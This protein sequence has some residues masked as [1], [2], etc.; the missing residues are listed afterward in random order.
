MTETPP[1]IHSFLIQNCFLGF[2]AICSRSSLVRNPFHAR[3]SLSLL[4]EPRVLLREGPLA[5]Q[6]TFAEP[7]V[8]QRVLANDPCWGETESVGE[9]G[10]APVGDPAGM[11][12]VELVG[13]PV[14]GVVV[15][16]TVDGEPVGQL[17]VGASVVGAPVVGDAVGA[18]VVGET[19]VHL[20]GVTVGNNVGV[21]VDG[22]PVGELVV[23]AS[24]VGASVVGDAVGA[25]AVGE[26]VGKM[27]GADVGDVGDAVV[28]VVAGHASSKLV[29]RP[30]PI[31]HKSEC[32]LRVT[33]AGVVAVEY[34]VDSTQLRWQASC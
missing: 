32:V 27:L 30:A 9:L 20:V 34:F 23:G 14:D 7:V 22:A 2:S 13:A 19:V 21:E 25:V 5:S 29:P 17:V 26:A 11:P 10:G 1:R 28:G 12:V 4:A 18:L 31:G 33:P 6:V 16:V 3:V 15:G 8:P 24:V